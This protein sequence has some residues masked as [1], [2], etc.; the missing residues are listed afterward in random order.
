MPLGGSYGH[1][2]DTTNLVTPVAMIL[3]V[4]LFDAAGDAIVID[5]QPVSA[6]TLPP[7]A[8]L[9]HSGPEM[10]LRLNGD[11]DV[12]LR[13]IPLTYWAE[14][15]AR[16]IHGTAFADV[17]PGTAGAD[18]LV[19]GGSKTLI[20]PGESVNSGPDLV[21]PGTGDDRIVFSL[22]NLTIGA[23]PPDSGTDTLDLRRFKRADLTLSRDGAD[24]MIATPDGTIRLVGQNS[25]DSNIETLLLDGKVPLTAA[26]LRAA[27]R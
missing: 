5:G 16:Q 20:E 8:I 26:D 27:A 22:G 19:P 24:L 7:G 18:V 3:R 17:L 1:P 9:T 21:L 23:T 11:D 6:T 10:I 15:A 4:T 14:G 25:A 13:G 2:P 12:I